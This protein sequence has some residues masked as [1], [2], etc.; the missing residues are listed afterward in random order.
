[1]N[2][3]A[4]S[5]LPNPL[6]SNRNKSI[7]SYD[8][9]ESEASKSKTLDSLLAPK[10]VV[11][12][13]LTAPIGPEPIKD[14]VPTTTKKTKEKQK[15]KVEQKTTAIEKKLPEKTPEPKTELITIAPSPVIDSLP[16]DT[17][18]AVVNVPQ[19]TILHPLPP[20]SNKS[21][22]KSLF[23]SHLLHPKEILPKIKKQ[24][25]EDW[26][27]GVLLLVVGIA[28][29]LNVSYR[30]RLRQLFNAFASNRFVAQIVREEN[31]MFQRIS[32]FLS[33]VFLLITS[34]FIFQLG[35]FF[36][37]PFSSNNSFI[38]YSVILI[39]LFAF[40]FIKISTF[41]FL[42]FLLRID[43]EM[44]EYVFT[45]FLYNHFIGVGLIPL[46]IILAFIPG[47]AHKGVFITGAIFFVFAFLLRAF[48]S[49]GNVSAGSRFSIFYLFLYLCTL[50][51]LPLVVITKLIINIV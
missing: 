25:H 18:S 33:L 28:C 42:G 12:F 3:G 1:M 43:K 6:D 8:I 21:Y 19:K 17:S 13:E 26:T 7:I 36:T 49:Y 4:F 24:E 39:S 32:I 50:E 40:Y 48:R 23:E 29:I 27:T 22:S 34:L 35:R 14:F 2:K 38:N 9:S 45:L 41:N 10:K 15:A 16:N 37:L 11:K 51:I 46:V 47:T 31:V 30:S 44:K 5:F 20:K